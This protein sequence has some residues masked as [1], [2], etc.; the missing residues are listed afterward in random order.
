KHYSAGKI[1]GGFI[2]REGRPS[3]KEILTSRLADRPIRPLFPDDFVNEV[4]I[5]IYVLSADRE[6]QPDILAIN[7]ASAALSISGI[8]F[9]GPVGAVRVGRVD[10]QW[11]VNPS[12]QE[13][14]N[15]DIDLVVAGTRKAVTM[16]EGQAKNLSEDAMIQAVEFAHEN[17]IKL[18]E[19]QEELKNAC[20]KPLMNYT[21]KQGDKELEKVIRDKYFTAVENFKE[22]TEKKAREDAK[23]AII[24]AITND[25]KEQFPDTIAL[26]PEIVDAMD[27][28]VIRSR[29]LDE[30]SRPDGRGLNNIRPIDIMVGILPRA[31][32]SAL[33]T[34]GQTQSLDS[35]PGYRC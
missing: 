35:Y 5:I 30:G 33:F 8:P 29:I 11:I 20:G 13:M 2:K 23:D 26:V 28:E 34:R 3:D 27:A 15:S 6:H 18:C 32:G 19:I 1:P 17:I 10:G 7:A 22:Y 12:F 14:E 4:Q 31:H 21:P 24:T 9:K 16:I 25:L